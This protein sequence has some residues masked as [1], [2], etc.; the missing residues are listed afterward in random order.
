MIPIVLASASPR[1]RALLTA[2]GIE[3]EV[4]VSAAD[5]T[6]DGVPNEVVLLNARVKRDDTAARVDR[7]AL[8]IAADTIVLLG[9]R[10]MGKPADLEEARAMIRALSGQTHEVLTGVAVRNTETQQTAEGFE[11]T[12]VTFRD[13]S[14]AEI[15]A[16][17][18]AVNPLDRAGAYTVDGPGSLLV[19]RYHG[20]FHNVLGLPIVCLDNL[21]RTM[22]DGLFSRMHGARARFL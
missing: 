21:L 16:F 19:E 12:K 15:G 11:S 4:I 17:V 20:C 5:E 14:D 6:L 7:P 1:R 10:I 8:V 2:L 9:D 3:I 22:G 18:E 13:L